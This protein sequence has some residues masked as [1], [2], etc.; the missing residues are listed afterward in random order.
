MRPAIDPHD[1]AALAL[2]HGAQVNNLN[3]A[4]SGQEALG[5]CRWTSC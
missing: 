1:G 4:L 5:R 3:A 2:P